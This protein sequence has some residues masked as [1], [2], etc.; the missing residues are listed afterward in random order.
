VTVGSSVNAWDIAGYT[1][2]HLFGLLRRNLEYVLELDAVAKMLEGQGG[3]ACRKVADHDEVLLDFLHVTRALLSEDV[4]V[5]ALESIA[6]QFEKSWRS[7][8]PLWSIV[9][10]IR[11]LSEVKTALPGVDASY[12]LLPVSQRLENL[13][14][15]RVFESDA[16]PFLA[17][18][19]E[20][21]QQ[22]LAEVRRK[23]Q[24]V[25][26]AVAVVVR[27]V[28]LRGSVR[29]LVRLE[30]P[31][32]FVVAQAELDAGWESRV[33]Q[34]IDYEGDMPPLRLERVQPGSA[35]P[36][37]D[38]VAPKGAAETLALWLEVLEETRPRLVKMARSRFT[39]EQVAAAVECLARSGIPV[40]DLSLVLDGLLSVRSVLGYAVGSVIVF[41]AGLGIASQHA[42]RKVEDLSMAERAETARQGI[43]RVISHRYAPGG[44]LKCLLLD[45]DIERIVADPAQI[46]DK[47]VRN[48]IIEAI[49]EEWGRLEEPGCVLLTS[50]EVRAK[51]EEL[52]QGRCGALAVIAYQDLS[53][54]LNV[55]PLARVAW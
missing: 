9:E 45:P 27:D 11:A 54:E 34:T 18:E 29:R 41:P 30:F 2:L 4:P 44:N 38:V 16:E 19:P 17:I 43:A 1:Y 32:L 12:S 3:E 8:V 26:F 49:R 24:Q 37:T 46:Q 48:R 6:A 40:A 36:N 50:T 15:A 25:D 52:L 22:V 31:Y 39:I 28:R 20:F 23:V 53:P 42:V 5:L 55:T 10:E 13:L 7:H 21:C 51:L 14:L 33:A 35:G 47:D